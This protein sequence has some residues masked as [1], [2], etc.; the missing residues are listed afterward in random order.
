MITITKDAPASA[1][2]FKPVYGHSG[3][4]DVAD[5]IREDTPFDV[6]AKRWKP[7]DDSFEWKRFTDCTW[8][9]CNRRPALYTASSAPLE[10]TGYRAVY[11]LP[12]PKP[13]EA[14]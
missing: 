13:G 11:W 4:L 7:E 10:E 12:I 3:R 6:W 1:S 14:K 9:W 8:N 5:E 2:P